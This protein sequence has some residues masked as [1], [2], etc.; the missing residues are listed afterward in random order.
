[1]LQFI[2]KKCLAKV[3]KRLLGM[4]AIAFS[5]FA[6]VADFL[7][8]GLFFRITNGMGSINMI[9]FLNNLI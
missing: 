2:L 7:A 1:M 8:F 9:N 6:V 3:F 5:V 4:L